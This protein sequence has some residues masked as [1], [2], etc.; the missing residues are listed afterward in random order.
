MMFLINL[1]YAMYQGYYANFYPING[2]FQNFNPVRRFLAGQVPYKD[3]QDY[4]G[5]G[6][7]YSGSIATKLFGGDYQSSLIAFSFLTTLS[8][9]LIL[10][11]AGLAITRKTEAAVS[12]TNIILVFLVTNSLV[13]DNIAGS[14]AIK[15]ALESALNTG[16][17]ARF[18][19]GLILP[20]SCF[21]IW[22]LYL[23]YVR[24]SNKWVKFGQ[25]E[26]LLRSCGVGAVAGFSFVWSNDYGISC[27]VCL[28]IMTSIILLSK[29]R[30]L[31]KTL[32][33]TTIE[34]LSST[35]SIFV[36]AEI[37]TGGHGLA[38]INATFGTGGYQSWYYNSGKSYF[39]YN[40]DFSYI[41]LVQAFLC[42]TYLLKLFRTKASYNAIIRYG[43]PAFMNMVSFCA[44]NEYQLLSGGG[45]YEV[46]LSV[47]FATIFFE[48]CNFI[49]TIGKE[50]VYSSIIIGSAVLGMAWLVSALK[51]EILF[52][53]TGERAG[54]YIS[55]MGGNMTA[56]G[57]D[58]IETSEF[59]DGDTFFSTYASAQEVVENTFQPSG[60]DYIIHVLGD[61]QREDYLNSFV[62]GHFRYAAT[63]KETYTP[64]EYWVQRANWFFYREL[65][66]NWHPVYA[67]TYEMYW[68]KN[69]ENEK[70]FL[71]NCYNVSIEELSNNKKKLILRTVT[72]VNGVADVYINY[73]VKKNHNK[74]TNM[75]FQKVLHIQNTGAVYAEEPWYESNYLRDAGAEYIPIPVVDGYGE[76]ILTSQ[77]ESATYLEVHQ[78]ECVGIYLVTSNYVEVSD[79]TNDN[80]NTLLTIANTTKNRE[81]MEGLSAVEIAN[82]EYIVSDKKLDENNIYISIF[83]EGN[84]TESTALLLK[85]NNMV[86]IIR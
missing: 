16:N 71:E 13:I 61:K 69:S 28:I 39:L 18:V 31:R 63:M 67:N 26:D 80:G 78:A 43:I 51:E 12:L 22:Q 35:I 44:V 1:L 66:K 59:L 30:D 20:V 24:L 53:N 76:V 56:L 62:N 38:W 55:S 42:L 48:V 64:Y 4:L 81:K 73:E 47:L 83:N 3:F 46:A 84:N 36:F 2:T 11:I 70:N 58:L 77:P 75:L 74:A 19:R 33:G 17:S 57:Q 86:R 60:T 54:I 15:K 68:E 8:L 85:K 49:I 82:E 29:T 40:V 65:Y 34:A 52:W 37:L 21:L 6:H 25:Y 14:E 72:P 23:T 32:L 9:T 5:L 10:L 45:L 7:L 79:I 41:M 27:W 50:K